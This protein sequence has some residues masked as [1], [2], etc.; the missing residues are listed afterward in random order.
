MTNK[1]NTIS[2]SLLAILFCLQASLFGDN[3]PP[4][5]QP[6]SFHQTTQLASFSQVSHRFEQM[7]AEL[8]QLRSQMQNASFGDGCDS[9]GYMACQCPTYRNGWFA[10]YE[11]VLVKPHFEDGVTFDPP[12]EL[13][14][15]RFDY[16]FSN[17]VFAGYRNCDG[18]GIRARYWNF[19]QN[20]TLAVDE[21]FFSMKA[22]VVDLEISKL[23]SIC[24][25]DFDLSGGIRYAAFETAT[26]DAQLPGFTLMQSDKYGPTVAL[27][28]LTPLG[29]SNFSFVGNFRAS[30]LYGRSSFFGDFIGFIV[31]EDNLTDVFESQIGIQYSHEFCNGGQ[32]VLRALIEGQLWGDALGGDT[33]S[34]DFTDTS[35]NLGFLGTTFSIIY[36]R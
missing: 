33:E 6:V 23:G 26:V 25:I 35:D 2:A 22:E 19:D 11:A 32:L 30:L 27:E 24:G 9:C 20:A 10:G 28:A 31:D 4:L 29:C 13:D 8:N 36:Y 15:P 14:E 1:S 18:L 3:E 34:L 12:G 21:E 16:E 5:A 17:R 7:Q